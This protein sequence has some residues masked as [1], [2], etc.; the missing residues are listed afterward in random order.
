MAPAANLSS[1]PCAPALPS[2][3]QTRRDAELLSSRSQQLTTDAKKKMA[4]SGVAP[5]W[6]DRDFATYNL[7]ARNSTS[8]G[9][10]HGAR[11]AQAQDYRTIGL[12]QLSVGRGNTCPALC[13]SL[14]QQG[15]AA[16]AQRA[17]EKAQE[18][19]QAKKAALLEAPV[20]WGRGSGRWHDHAWNAS[21]IGEPRAGRQLEPS[22]VFAALRVCLQEEIQPPAAAGPTTPEVVPQASVRV[23]CRALGWEGCWQVG[24]IALLRMTRCVHML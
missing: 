19:F 21:V 12:P 15:A 20:G 5:A 16:L 10:D 3:L 14:P 23:C 7:L 11:A 24:N 4:V 6:N 17:F 2:P 1:V 13:F 8:R 22:A 18:S 9:G